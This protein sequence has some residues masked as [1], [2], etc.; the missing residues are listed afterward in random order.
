MSE[1]DDDQEWNDAWSDDDGEE[2]LQ[3]TSEPEEADPESPPASASEPA[4]PD[5][6]L[7]SMK[8]K[9]RS[10]EG[11]LQKFEEHIDDLRS[12]ITTREQ[13][14]EE[15][16]AQAEPVLPDGWTKDDW[17]DYESDYPVQAELTEKQTK[18]VKELEQRLSKTEQELAL[19]EQQR[20]FDE[21]IHKAHP[22]YN[23]L[24]SSER[25]Q[26]L[27][28]IEGQSNPTLKAAYQAIY[29]GGDAPDIINLVSDY[30]ASKDSGKS[31][32]TVSRSVDNALA[33]PGRHQQ[34]THLSGKAGLPP[35]D[36]FS[37]GWEFFKD[38]AID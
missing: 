5:D 11:R 18:S 21:Q 38:E 24:L 6:D 15:S 7:E 3:D 13:P 32:S 33:V 22:D 34:P 16:P 19:K 9:L 26:I 29:K 17:Q 1:K 30:K 10:A 8:H 14:E 12:Q 2:A 36:D 31:T 35:D 23:D 25:D 37:A 27:Q 20:S 4:A 28:F